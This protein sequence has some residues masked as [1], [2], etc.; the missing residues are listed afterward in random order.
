[1]EYK[2]HEVWV[3]KSGNFALIVSSTGV[4]TKFGFSQDHM[5]MFITKGNSPT[6][7]IGEILDRLDCKMEEMTSADFY[8]IAMRTK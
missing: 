1:M 6:V 5:A 4:K 8:A 2:H 3:T 7:F